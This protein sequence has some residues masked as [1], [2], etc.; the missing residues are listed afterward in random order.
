MKYFKG[1]IEQYRALNE[2]ISSR[3]HYPNYGTES[4]YPDEPA[5]DINGMAVMQVDGFII[6]LMPDVFEGIELHE[7]VEY[8][9][10]NT[11]LEC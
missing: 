8:E 10:T 5:F 4:Y 9:Q 11:E 2:A 3:F 1:T 6:D 7:T